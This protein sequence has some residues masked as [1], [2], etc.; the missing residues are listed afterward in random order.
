MMN[1]RTPALIGAA[2]L[3]AMVAGVASFWFL[4]QEAPAASIQTG[5]PVEDGTVFSLSSPVDPSMP[6]IPLDRDEPIEMVVYLTPTCGCCSGW[7]DHVEEYGF[8]VERRYVN[9]PE[10]F[11]FKEANDVRPE[12]SSCHTAIVNGYV[13]EGHIPGEVVRQFLADAPAVRGITVPGMPI[14]SP[15][16]EMGDHVDPY[17]VLAFTSDGRTVVYSRQGRN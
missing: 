16:M 7:V 9:D 8:D 17:D 4:S 11:A 6:S 2:F 1:N 5:I 10:L 14:G 13:L 3:V 15:G 12:L